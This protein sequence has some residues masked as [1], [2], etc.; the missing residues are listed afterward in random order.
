VTGQTPVKESMND[1][2]GGNTQTNMKLMSH[3]NLS[4]DKDELK[5]KG[6][7]LL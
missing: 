4:Y 2:G 6:P 7:E 5:L 3:T 1:L